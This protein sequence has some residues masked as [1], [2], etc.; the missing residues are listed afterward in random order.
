MLEKSEN[1]SVIA[2]FSG[3][4]MKETFFVAK[5]VPQKNPTPGSHMR[6]GLFQCSIFPSNV[7]I[8]TVDLHT[9]N[10]GKL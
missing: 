10:N 1:N 5:K 7:L 6:R 2:T 4:Q 8:N 3:K 9:Y